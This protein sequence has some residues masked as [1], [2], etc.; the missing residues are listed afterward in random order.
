MTKAENSIVRPERLNRVEGNER[1]TNRLESDN[2][3]GNRSSPIETSNSRISVTRPSF[4]AF[5]KTVVISMAPTST[6]ADIA[7]VNNSAGEKR[8]RI[9]MAMSAATMSAMRTGSI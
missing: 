6:Q 5:A 7:T 9:S 4:V 3:Q 1:L 2:S 8:L